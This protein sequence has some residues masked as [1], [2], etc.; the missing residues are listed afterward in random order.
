MNGPHDFGGTMGHGPIAPEADE[1]IF[2]A[3]W[4]RRALAI[5]LAMGA[6]GA[7]N[8]DTSRHARERI[9]PKRYLAAS[10]YEIWI[11]GLTTLLKERGDPK[12][13]L[14]AGMVEG[15]LAK[16]GPANRP[17]DRAPAFKPGDIIRTRNI[18][19][20]GHTRLPR[21][22]RGRLGEIVMVHGTHVFADSSAHGKGDDPHWLYAVRFTAKE[23]WGR[24]EN[25]S[26]TLD[27][28]EPY[29]EPA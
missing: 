15:V 28:W 23:L 21:Y 1:P 3:E 24:D 5:S 7:W 9:P 18:H 17:L 14:Q 12:R 11:E 29:L 8:I 2:H 4:E 10:Y 13:V 22:A 27:L 20:E 16:G 25:G 26:V 6:T 19:V